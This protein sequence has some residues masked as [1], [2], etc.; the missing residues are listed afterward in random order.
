MLGRHRVD[1]AYLLLQGC[2]CIYG[3]SCLDCWCLEFIL[4][5]E[6]PIPSSCCVFI[7]VMNVIA[8]SYGYGCVT[9]SRTI[10]YPCWCTPAESVIIHS[11]RERK[12]FS[13]PLISTH[14]ENLTQTQEV[15][16]QNRVSGI[17]SRRSSWFQSINSKGMEKR[18]KCFICASEHGDGL[19][20]GN[21]HLRSK[22]VIIASMWYPLFLL[23]YA[24]SKL[25]FS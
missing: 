9:L 5:I 10:W 7:L 24:E 4:W 16:K 6:S 11:N 14:E 3:V 23:P 13:I 19:R 20:L 17:L 8:L 2:I 18:G 25:V 12:K 15:W 1:V 22:E 21:T